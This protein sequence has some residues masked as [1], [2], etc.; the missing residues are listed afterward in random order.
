MRASFLGMTSIRLHRRAGLIGAMLLAACARPAPTPVPVTPAPTD[1][2]SA[3]AAPRDTTVVTS[4]A[5]PATAAMPAAATRQEPALQPPP[6]EHALL[7]LPA[8]ITMGAGEGFTVDSTTTTVT[9]DSGSGR[10]VMRLARGLARMIGRDTAPAVRRLTSAAAAG[11]DTGTNTF[12]LRIDTAAVAHD[13][14]YALTVTRERVQLVAR[15]PEGLFRGIQTIRQLFP[16]VVEHR[17]ALVRR[18]RLPAVQ[19]QDA[20]R[21]TWRGSMLDVSRHFLPL[22]AVKQHI[23]AMVLYKLN[24]L[25]LHLSDDQGWRIEIRKYPRLA[26]VGGRSQVG[27]GPGGY[28]TQA[29]FRELVQYA[30][31]RY[32]M[33]IPEIDMPGH[34]NAALSAVPALNCDRK[35]AKPYTGIKVGFSAVC[36]TREATYRWVNDVV[37]EIAAISPSPYI[38]LGGDEVEKIPHAEYLKFMERVERIVRSHG[39]TMIGWGEIAP[40]KLDT[41][42]IVQHWRGAGRD[43]SAVHVA[44]GGRVILSPGPKMYIDMKYDANGMLG[45]RWA[46]MIEVRDTYDWNPATYLAGVEERSILGVE[47][48]LWSETV[49][50]ASDFQFLAFP[51][52]LAVAEL[53]WSPQVARDWEDFRQRLGAHGP[54]MQALGIN[55]YRSPQVEWDASPRPMGSPRQPGAL[56]P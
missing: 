34:T 30:A 13:E 32:V 17:A 9:V 24:R 25:H 50:K 39:K 42:T 37:R 7:P 2:T 49:E 22:E 6:L 14:G 33:I 8:S 18:L 40:A 12:H 31:E 36:H 15:T 51:R 23:D 29:Q 10:E 3:A 19:I 46:G 45:L 1:T 4:A 26:R 44:R 52:L 5:A 20:P 27:G 43:S 35:A 38:H 54:R 55:F 53:G 16:V 28:Y 41:A 47:A 48:P 11:V 56:V 21:Y